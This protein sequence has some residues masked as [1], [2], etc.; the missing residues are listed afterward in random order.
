MQGKAA[1]LNKRHLYNWTVI[2]ELAHATEKPHTAPIKL[3]AFIPRANTASACQKT[4]TQLIRQRRS[5]Q[6]F[7]PQ[8][9]LAEQD[10]YRILTATLPDKLPFDVWSPPNN[11]HL[12][13]FVHRVERLEAGL[14]G[15]VL[16]LEAEAAGV[17]G[18]GYRL[19][20]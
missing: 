3:P 1:L 16:Y 12:F 15:Q 18:Y 11:T 6:H 9:T 13:I 2:N 7:N 8:P 5:A 20:F 10:F 14:T 19:L 17:R 4:A